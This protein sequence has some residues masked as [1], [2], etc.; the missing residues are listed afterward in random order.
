MSEILPNTI[1]KSNRKGAK[2]R[3]MGSK[4]QKMN[5]IVNMDRLQ[6]KINQ[7]TWHGQIITENEPKDLTMTEN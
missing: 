5:Q 4:Q 7:R 1:T 6:Q 2:G 3:Y